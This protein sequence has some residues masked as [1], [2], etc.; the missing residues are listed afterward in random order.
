MTRP[1]TKDV[2]DWLA[3]ADHLEKQIEKFNSD[4]LTN[5]YAVWCRKMAQI[6]SAV[7]KAEIKVGTTVNEAGEVEQSSDDPFNLIIKALKVM[8]E[9]KPTM[10][11]INWLRQN[12]GLKKEEEKTAYNP[13][14]ANANKKR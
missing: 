6:T 10:E 12:A 14:E 9:A 13:I 2:R 3:Y 5:T 7:D 11:T 1:E 4:P 8:N